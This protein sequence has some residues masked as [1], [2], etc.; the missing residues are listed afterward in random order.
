MLV[1]F[2]YLG[3]C[4]PNKSESLPPDD[5]P[6]RSMSEVVDVDGDEIA[7]DETADNLEP[8]ALS[9]DLPA[10]GAL[11]DTAD[12]QMTGQVQNLSSGRLRVNGNEVQANADGTFA[13]DVS[14]TNGLNRIIT[15]VERGDSIVEDRRA[16]ILG[17][18]RNADRRLDKA[19]SL[20]LGKQGLDALG[21][22]LTQAITEVDLGDL[23]QDGDSVSDDFKVKSVE[24]SGVVVKLEPRSNRVRT[25][26]TIF[27]LK[28]AF[29]AEVDVLF[30]PVVMHGVAAADAVEI[31]ANLY[32]EKT[33]E[34]GLDF[35]ISNSQLNL[36]GFE[37]DVENVS[38]FITEKLERS[39]QR[40]GEEL[41]RK[42]LAEV[43]IPKLFDERMLE[44]EVDIL[45]RR[46]VIDLEIDRVIA[47][48]SGFT[49]VAGSQVTTSSMLREM[50]FV[51][52]QVPLAQRSPQSGL[53]LSASVGFINHL[54][55]TGWSAGVFD[56]EFSSEDE[57]LRAF[58]P[59]V[60]KVSLGESARGLANDDVLVYRF[61]PLLPP[62]AAADGVNTPLRFDMID[63]VL[64]I[65][66]PNGTLASIALDF[67]VA[68]GLGAAD[69]RTL[70]IEP[71]FVT[72]VVARVIDT[73]NGSVNASALER[74]VESAVLLLP[75]WFADGT[76]NVGNSISELPLRVYDVGFTASANNQWL[77]ISAS[78]E[79]L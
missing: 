63:I 27:D 51:P 65:V 5:T 46:I 31:V 66:G 32:A 33:D 79:S 78:F 15:E 76:M 41:L 12:I 18:E 39:V 75:R 48:R 37:L 52:V 53:Q 42:T 50:L 13:V 8:L 49:L 29:R 4:T 2:L 70:S 45:G 57:L 59:A 16:V 60:M 56:A 71:E 3:G 35:E 21:R 6:L 40:K 74:Q 34:G 69:G 30:V 38:D 72:D 25:R 11:V 44:Q 14:V 23:L 55:A 62:V 1:S 64:E 36:L 22:V 10:R 54:L 47:D 19:V 28:I 7:A 61:K 20:H 58:G 73:P 67:S 17:A 9:I 77:D 26:L 43:V 68:V 24:Y